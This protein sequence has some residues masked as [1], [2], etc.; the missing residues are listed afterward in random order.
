M[1][2]PLEPEVTAPPVAVALPVVVLL[3]ASVKSPLASMTIFAGM[4]A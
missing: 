3:D 1:A 4:V 2:I